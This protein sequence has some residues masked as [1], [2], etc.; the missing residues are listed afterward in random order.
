MKNFIVNFI[1]FSNIQYKMNNIK[2]KIIIKKSDFE[3]ESKR[4]DFNHPSV[5]KEIYH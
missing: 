5:L 3:A 1:E 4:L 2:A